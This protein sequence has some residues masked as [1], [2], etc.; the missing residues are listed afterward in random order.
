LL[1]SCDANISCNGSKQGQD[2]AFCSALN[3]GFFPSDEVCLVHDETL[4][5]ANER[6]DEWE[7]AVDKRI[8]AVGNWAS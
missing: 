5:T 8:M 4:V 3:Y 6:E 7:I 1:D 2:A